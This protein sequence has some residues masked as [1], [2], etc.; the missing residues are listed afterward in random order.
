VEI[1]RVL[2]YDGGMVGLRLVL[3]LV[4]SVVLDSS[5]LLVPESMEGLKEPQEA[6]RVLHRRQPLRSVR[7]VSVPPA[8]GPTQTILVQPIQATSWKPPARPVTSGWVR[9]TPPSVPDSP[10]APEDH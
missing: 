6:V 2:L 3:F 5:A 8:A 9:K 4:L 7:D 1:R 10:S